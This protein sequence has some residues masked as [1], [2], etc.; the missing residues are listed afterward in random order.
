[1][2]ALPRTAKLPAHR[3]TSRSA[4]PV[5]ASAS[6][7]GLLRPLPVTAL[8]PARR[9]DLMDGGAQDNQGIAG[10]PRGARPRTSRSSASIVQR[11]RRSAQDERV[12]ETPLAVAVG[13]VIG[14]QGDRI[15][16]EQLLARR[17]ARRRRAERS[18]T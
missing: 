11:R 1:M 6:V 15:R 7:P 4:M 3:R 8:Y 10:A 13:R 9:I 18:S 16:E 14:V 2:L 12:D 5:V 17:A